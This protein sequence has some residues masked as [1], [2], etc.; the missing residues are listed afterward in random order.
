VV[1]SPVPVGAVRQKRGMMPEAGER[2]RAEVALVRVEAG[3][4][5]EEIG[6]KV[7]G[8]ILGVMRW[9]PEAAAQAVRHALGHA[10]QGFE[11]G[12]GE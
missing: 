7:L 11:L 6:Q 1:E 10:V 8:E 12:E 9:Q 4:A 5:G 2:E 3:Q